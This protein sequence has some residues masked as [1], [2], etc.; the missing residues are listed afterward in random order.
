[1]RSLPSFGVPVLVLC[2]LAS[3]GCDQTQAAFSVNGP[4]PLVVAAS[5]NVGVESSSVAPDYYHS[6]SCPG[7]RPFGARVG[8]RIHG[9]HDVILRGMRFSYVD[10]VGAPSLPTVIPIPTLST[11]VSLPSSVHTTSPVSVPGF[12]PLPSTTLIP[13]P[14]SSPIEGVVVS[15]GHSRMFPYFAQFGCG[16]LPG[17]VIVIVV[18]TGDRQGKSASAEL[19]VAVR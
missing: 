18:D 7:P 3:A 10:R 4:A 16:V 19:R 1:M 15:G 8:V 13:I 6:P 11:P 14:G 2:V 5:V 17:G 9:D 12:A